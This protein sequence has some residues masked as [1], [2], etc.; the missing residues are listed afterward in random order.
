MVAI[1]GK[2]RV[3]KTRRE[4]KGTRGEEHERRIQGKEGEMEEDAPWNR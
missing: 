4:K 3:S 2:D 1:C